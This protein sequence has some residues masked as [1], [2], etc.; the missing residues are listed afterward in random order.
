MKR[1][2]NTHSPSVVGLRAGSYHFVVDMGGSFGGFVDVYKETS[3]LALC[4]EE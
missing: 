1:A 3:I 2:M 4:K